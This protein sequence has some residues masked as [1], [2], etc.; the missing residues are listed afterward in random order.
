MISAARDYA[1]KPWKVGFRTFFKFHVHFSFNFF[2]LEK[3]YSVL[4]NILIF[5]GF[6]PDNELNQ[7]QIGI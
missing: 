6:K 3:K 4:E 1:V 2:R 5:A 7:K